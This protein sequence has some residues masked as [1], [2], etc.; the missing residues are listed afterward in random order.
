[1]K[2]ETDDEHQNPGDDI[3]IGKHPIHV[4]QSPPPSYSLEHRVDDGVD[5]HSAQYG[6]L[7]RPTRLPS[8]RIAPNLRELPGSVGPWIPLRSI[9]ATGW[10]VGEG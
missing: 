3:R 1:M 9:Q 5:F 6:W 8:G 4:V 10:I 7:L 2:A